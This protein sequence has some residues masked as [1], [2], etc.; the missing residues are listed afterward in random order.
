MQRP[1][2]I[3]KQKET[4][5]IKTA[6]LACVK[7]KMQQFRRNTKRY[8]TFESFLGAGDHSFSGDVQARPVTAAVDGVSYIAD[9]LKKEN[10]DDEVTLW[11]LMA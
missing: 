7:G 4:L 6:N 3:N 2:D 8:S 1:G 9:Y 10:M 11:D 5:T